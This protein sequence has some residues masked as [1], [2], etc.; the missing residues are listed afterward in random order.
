MT[1][2]NWVLTIKNDRIQLKHDHR[3]EDGS[4]D[5]VTQPG[6]TSIPVQQRFNFPASTNKLMI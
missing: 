4:E 1:S 2:Q 3:H 6:T 5:A